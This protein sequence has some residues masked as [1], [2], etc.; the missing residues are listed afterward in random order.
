M[1]SKSR[2]REYS[3]ANYLRQR[4]VLATL[5]STPVRVSNIRSREDDPGIVEAEAGFIR[6]L[7]KLANG[8]KVEV[9]ETGTQLSYQPGA[10]LGGKVE[11]SCS[12]TRG[13]GYWLEPIL[14]LA[15]FCKEPLHLVLTGVTNSQ[16]ISGTLI[17]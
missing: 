1:G 4:L 14:A 10:L 6:L 17:T 15:P 9:N 7:D 16:V 8:S 5:T 13:V 12:L 11:H 2:W 3:G